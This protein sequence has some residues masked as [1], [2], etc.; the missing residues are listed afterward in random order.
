M[1]SKPPNRCSMYHRM[2][3]GAPG[4]SVTYRHITLKSVVK[5]VPLS[6]DISPSNFSLSGF[7]EEDIYSDNAKTVR[8]FKDVVVDVLDHFALQMTANVS[9][10]PKTLGLPAAVPRCK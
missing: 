8:E 1:R 7:L 6:P 2:I 3:T 4:K 5:C 9:I 10:D